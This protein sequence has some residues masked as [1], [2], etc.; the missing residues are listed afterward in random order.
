VLSRSA[1]PPLTSS[2]DDAGSRANAYVRCQ[3]LL[4]AAGLLCGVKPVVIAIILQATWRLGRSA[5]KSVSVA[6]VGI[7]AIAAYAYGMNEIAI[8]G[9]AAVAMAALHGARRLRISGGGLRV[10]SAGLLPG[11]AVSAAPTTAAAASAFA[12]GEPFLVF[13]KIGTVLFGSGYVLVAVL[14]TVGIFLP[15]L[16]FVAASGPLVPRIRQSPLAGTMLDGIVIAPLA[17]MAGAALLLFW[18][19]SSSTRPDERTLGPAP[20]SANV[21]RTRRAGR[22]GSSVASP[23]IVGNQRVAPQ[24]APDSIVPC[25][26]GPPGRRP[27]RP[28]VAMVA[29][30]MG[31][32]LDFGFSL[33]LI[34]RGHQPGHLPQGGG[35]ATAWSR[36]KMSGCT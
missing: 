5:V 14:A 1:G 8:L 2:S 13:L 34:L 35:P 9:A 29:V 11:L 25:R 36:V 15:A 3:S 10:F 20:T 31:S 26:A 24:G 23:R 28:E 19:L 7:A 21:G 16:V 18:F 4:E 32:F 17:L 33:A 30:T 6:L 27:Q 22:N 12:L